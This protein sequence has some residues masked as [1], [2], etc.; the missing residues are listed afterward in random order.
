VSKKINDIKQLTED[1]DQR[2]KLGDLVTATS[3][4]PGWSDDQ[5]KLTGGIVIDTDSPA[6]SHGMWSR[7]FYKVLWPYDLVED[8]PDDW[9]SGLDRLAV[10]DERN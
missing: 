2:F 4:H 8:V 3:N 10:Q 9:I 7:K 5:D 1:L 6:P